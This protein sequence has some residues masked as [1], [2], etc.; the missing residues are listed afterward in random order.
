[1]LNLTRKEII[2]EVRFALTMRLKEQYPDMEGARGFLQTTEAYFMKTMYGVN[3]KECRAD[4]YVAPGDGGGPIMVEVGD[5]TDPKWE[6]IVSLDQAPVRVLH[7]GLD[8]VMSLRH[9]R[10]TQFEKDML[11][12]VQLGLKPT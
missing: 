5:T 1:M 6:E 9:P 4:Y 12:A 8:R 3:L 7:I 11:Q 2:G 10:H